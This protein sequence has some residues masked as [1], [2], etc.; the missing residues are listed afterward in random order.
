M[1]SQ[2]VLEGNWTQVEGKIRKRWRQ[3]THDELEGVKGNT[4]QLVG[5]LQRKTGEAREAIEG[6][7]DEVTE[8]QEK[9]LDTAKDYANRAGETI[10][11]AVEKVRDSAEAAYSETEHLVQARPAQSMAVV[12]GAGVLTGL[13]V[14]MCLRSR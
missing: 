14:G 10:Q 5:L 11:H 12:F 13:I 7:L 4:D 2:K 1:V 3:L 8:S 6:F 9:L